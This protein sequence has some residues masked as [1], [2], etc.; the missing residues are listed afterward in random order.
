[1]I[2]VTLHRTK[3]IGCIACTEHAPQ[4]WRMSKKDGKSVLLG[5]KETKKNVFN[6][7]VTE[8][9]LESNL[10]AAEACPVRIIKVEV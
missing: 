4:R 7:A 5:G 8:D 2:Q 9:E 1:M 3:C 10:K 6:V